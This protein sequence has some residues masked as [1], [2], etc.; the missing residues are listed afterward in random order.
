[1]PTTHR[2]PW[3]RRALTSGLTVYRHGQKHDTQS[4]RRVWQ[5]RSSTF[6]PAL[7]IQKQ[8][9]LRAWSWEL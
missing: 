2:Q 8:D 1:M 7:F 9:F 6:P 5:G 3:F 4:K